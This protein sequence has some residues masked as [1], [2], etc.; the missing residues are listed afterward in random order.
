MGLHI[1]TGCDSTSAFYGK[2]KKR[3]FAILNSNK[4]YTSAFGNLGESFEVEKSVAKVLEEFVIELYGWQST[5]SIN[6][7][8]YKSFCAPGFSHQNLPPT[9]DELSLHITR[10]NYQTAIH[11]RCLLQYINA[12]DP[13]EHGWEEDSNG[14]LAVQ[15]MTK[16]TAPEE[17]LQVVFCSCQVTKCLSNKCSCK[18]MQLPCTDICNCSTCENNISPPS[19]YIASD[20]DSDNDTS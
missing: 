14:N 19:Q 3:G 6:E 1:F 7:A 11:K 8:R 15:W 20:D 5:P 13:L 18:S 16:D 10:C 17:L 4:K 2:G 9:E 12:P